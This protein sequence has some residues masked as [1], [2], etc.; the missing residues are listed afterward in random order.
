MGVDWILLRQVYWLSAKILTIVVTIT[1]IA[2][3]TLDAIYIH[4]WFST[5]DA[6]TVP[7]VQVVIMMAGIFCHELIKRTQKRQLHAKA[8]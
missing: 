2:Y 5:K 6:A 1:L 3:I 4:T 8:T 7:L